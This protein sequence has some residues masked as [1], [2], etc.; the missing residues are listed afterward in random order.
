MLILAARRIASMLLIMFTVSFLL[1][2]IFETDKLGV[3]GKVLGP[4]STQQQRELWLDVVRRAA[5]RQVREEG[6]GQGTSETGSET[7]GPENV[8]LHGSGPDGESRRHQ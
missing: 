6:M 7:R 8:G 5:K 2:L 3:A 4:Y 1:F